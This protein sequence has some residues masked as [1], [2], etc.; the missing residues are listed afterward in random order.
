MF[1]GH[2]LLDKAIELLP[3]TQRHDFENYINNQTKFYPNIMVISKKKILK[4]WFEGLFK[5]LFNCEKI[6]GF[7]ELVGYDKGRLYAYLSE[8]YLSFWF[9]YY[10]KTR[11]ISWKFFDTVKH[12]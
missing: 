6:F 11:Q 3:D 5:W 12:D 2:G 1:H 9:S 8:R 4:Q 7:S 10:Y